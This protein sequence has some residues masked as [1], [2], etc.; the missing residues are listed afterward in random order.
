LMTYLGLS[1]TAR[2]SFYFYNSL[3]DADKLVDAIIATKE[4][5]KDGTI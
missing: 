3:E 4:F 5:F 1:A 2:A